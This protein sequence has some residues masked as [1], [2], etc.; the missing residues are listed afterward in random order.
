MRKLCNCAHA[1]NICVVKSSEFFSDSYML[2]RTHNFES[3]S[4]AHVLSM[5]TDTDSHDMH[6]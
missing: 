4:V 6:K 5:C 1:E 3:L 2:Y